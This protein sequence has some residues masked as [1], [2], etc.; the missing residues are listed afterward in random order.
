MFNFLFG[1]KKALE[2][3]ERKFA[4]LKKYLFKL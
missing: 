2:K 4:N 1:S 3:S